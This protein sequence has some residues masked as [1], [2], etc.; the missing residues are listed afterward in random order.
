MLNQKFCCSLN[1]HAYSRLFINLTQHH[2]VRKS[3][4]S[5]LFNSSIEKGSLNRLSIGNVHRTY[6]FECFSCA[7]SI[8]KPFND[9]WLLRVYHNN[10]KH[11]LQF[12]WKFIPIALAKL[13]MKFIEFVRHHLTTFAKQKNDRN[14]P[15]HKKKYCNQSNFICIGRLLKNNKFQMKREN[16][17]NRIRN[18]PIQTI[19]PTTSYLSQ[20]V[21]I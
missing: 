5:S 21:S 8:C 1:C 11:S 4:L 14:R 19:E 9:G 12:I 7:N 16:L 15:K 13:V 17:K 18:Q 2:K 20:K 3:C 6:L 10:N